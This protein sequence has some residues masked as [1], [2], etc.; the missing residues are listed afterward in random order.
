[1]LISTATLQLSSNPRG[2]DFSNKKIKIN[3]SVCFSSCRA[4]LK[5]FQ[6][7]QTVAVKTPLQKQKSPGR[8]FQRQY[9]IF[10]QAQFPEVH[11]SATILQERWGEE[12]NQ[13]KAKTLHVIKNESK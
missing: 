11:L 13:P 1:M 10:L 9:R 3:L 12:V 5:Y 8:H 4:V 6:Q 2:E 7:C